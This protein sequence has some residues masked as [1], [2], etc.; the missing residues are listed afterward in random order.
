MSVQRRH[1]HRRSCRSSVP[2]PARPAAENT[3]QEKERAKGEDFGR[4]PA[5]G[6][7]ETASPRKK[8]RIAAKGLRRIPE[9]LSNRPRRTLAGE[10]GLIRAN[11]DERRLD[12]D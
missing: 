7:P 11:S 12:R 8:T 1:K 4:T 10:G 5:R 3:G 6:R 9:S 2:S